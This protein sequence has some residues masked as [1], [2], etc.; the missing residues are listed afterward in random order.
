MRAPRNARELF[1][2]CFEDGPLRASATST[3]KSATQTTW[4]F[5]PHERWDADELGK[6]VVVRALELNMSARANAAL[7]ALALNERA[8]G[9]AMAVSNLGGAFH[10]VPDVFE[11]W[12]CAETEELREAVEAALRDVECEFDKK[13]VMV[14]Q[15]MGRGDGAKVSTSWVNVCDGV[16][17]QGHGLHN[18][19]NAVWS[20]VYYA[21]TSA[22]DRDDED[23]EDQPGDLLIRITAGGFNPLAKPGENSGYF[24]YHRIA[25][26]PSRLVIF[27]SWVYH[28]VL[29]NDIG[30]SAPRV[31]FA[32]NS[33]ET[34]VS[35]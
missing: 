34:G 4:V 21:A 30:S 18:H 10:S 1:G 20:G 24:R 13:K 9:R 14:K 33:G 19:V 3:T 11:R 2:E 31:S 23:E 25:P 15:C 17:E 12:K 26:K 16:G 7:V 8:N 27:P 32:F 22:T 6:T 5:G 35:F 29:A 28:G